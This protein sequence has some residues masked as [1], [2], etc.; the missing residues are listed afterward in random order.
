VMLLEFFFDNVI[1]SKRPAEAQERS[2]LL[3]VLQTV[4]RLLQ[5]T[6]H[7]CALGSQ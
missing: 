7:S 6:A 5:A 4:F 2:N 3:K 1:A